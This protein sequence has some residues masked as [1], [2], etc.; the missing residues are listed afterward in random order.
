MA[1]GSTPGDLFLSSLTP[2]SIVGELPSWDVRLPAT[3]RGNDIDEVFRRDS[4][5]PGVL[6]FERSG[7]RGAI[8]RTQFQNVISRPFGGEIVRPRAIG[9]L[10][11]EFWGGGLLILDLELP[12]Q[13]ALRRALGRDRS[14]MYEPV[15]T[16]A[17]GTR[18]VR[19][20]G[21][22][23]LLRADS[24]ISVL[25]NRQMQEILATVQEG[26]LLVERDHQ[27]AGEYSASVETIFGRPDVAHRTF[28]S[29]IRDLADDERAELAYDYLETLFNP[30]VIEKLVA[31]INPLVSVT[32]PARDGRA[33]RHLAFTFRRSLEG[34]DIRRILVRVEDRTREVELSAEVEEQERQ[35]RQRLDVAMEMM[36]V[37]P[38]ALTDYLTRFL[39]ELSQMGRLRLQLNGSP[40]ARPAVDSIFRVLHGLKGE[41]GVI[42]LRSFAERLH[43]TEDAVAGMRE[44]GVTADLLRDLD[45]CLDLLRTLGA[46]AKDLIGRLS[47]LASKTPVAEKAPPRAPDVAAAAGSLISDLSKRLAKPARFIAHWNPADLPPEYEPLVRDALIQFARNSMVHGIE[48]EIERRR[49]GKE[50]EA[51]LQLAIRLHQEGRQIEIVFQ[52]D[53]RGIDPKVAPLV[54]DPGFSTASETTEDAGRGV[55]LDLVKEKVEGAGGA[56]L[57]H[58]EPGAF[59][60]FQIVLPLRGEVRP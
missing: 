51:V 46:E 55:G 28:S 7:V 45:R 22:T 33:A 20:V 8:S 58:S 10:L 36:Q 57:V 11:D 53:G 17:D 29:V 32:A 31:D 21:F 50:I 38:Q 26:F 47:K 30:N 56:I 3:S 60:A 24:R 5:V 15:L 4:E 37:D 48:T 12:I 13:E 40:A 42:G 44:R 19:L 39:A 2:Q 6:I 9:S 18:D 27:I 14:M 49:A 54:F 25:R 16:A 43:R 41:A 1:T 34:R 35:A 23:D 52:D 59:C